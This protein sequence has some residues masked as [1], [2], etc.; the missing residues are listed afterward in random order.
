[1]VE[2]TGTDFPLGGLGMFPRK[3]VITHELEMAI[4]LCYHFMNIYNKVYE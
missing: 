3:D 4:Q 2:S 1:M